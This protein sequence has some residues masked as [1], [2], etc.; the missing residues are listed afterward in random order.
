[1]RARRYCLSVLFT[2]LSMSAAAAD[3]E[4]QRAVL[5]YGLWNNRVQTLYDLGEEG[6]DGLALLSYSS[7][8]ADWQVRL[9]AVHFM[10]KL[11][12][13]AAPAL[14]EIVRV[15]PCPYVRVSALRWLT[16]MGAAGSGILREVMTPEDEAE[17]ESIPDR[18]GTER[19]GKPLIIDA[20]GGA[21]TSEFFNHGLDLRVCASSEYANRRKRFIVPSRARAAEASPASVRREAPP[22]PD[23]S[24]P[25]VT[26][27]VR[28]AKAAVKKPERLPDSPP[29][30]P[31]M[32][33]E[34][35][36]PNPGP[37]ESE[38]RPP[39]PEAFP[40]AGP[41]AP[42][43]ARIASPGSKEPQRRTQNPELDDLLSAKAP[44]TMPQAGSGFGP[45]EAP[46]PAVDSAKAPGAR[47]IAAT[48]PAPPRAPLPPAET[49]PA[50]GPG[51]YHEPSEPGAASLVDDAGTGKPE[52]DPVPELIKRLS[53]AEPRTRARAAD[54]L[55]KRGASALPAV[56]ALRRALK[57]RDR[58]VR[59]SAVLALGGVA[60]S[61]DGVYGDLHRALRDKN[62]DVRF[63]AVIALQRLQAPS[64]TK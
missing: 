12:A 27:P 51:I 28:I 17:M 62:E 30:A 41:A 25:V 55:G 56:S 32:V 33:I 52:N 29:G 60:G 64:K 26:P 53:S 8:D 20:P 15:E 48:P 35:Q 61:V 21:M 63:S 11:G 19:M 57:D 1:M 5:D 36:I 59:A 6:R 23:S 43:A 49:F 38:K 22:R 46:V 39:G 24:E 18:F 10:G 31:V 44:E 14:G 50:A 34:V 45:R 54:E 40:P 2:A 47:P 16:G 37:K 58:R 7:D 13:P 4:R 42:N 3:S 9:T